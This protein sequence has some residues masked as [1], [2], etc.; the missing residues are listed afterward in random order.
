MTAVLYRQDALFSE[1]PE[2][3]F[4]D[5][6]LDPFENESNPIFDE[7]FREINSRPQRRPQ[8]H[9]EVVEGEAVTAVVPFVELGPAEL[10]LPLP[11]SRFQDKVDRWL[12]KARHTV[13]HHWNAFINATI[14][15]D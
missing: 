8:P 10:A 9:P 3:R 11:K 1:Y 13:R 15:R 4:D 12:L 2:E 6:P 14:P 5:M 7:L